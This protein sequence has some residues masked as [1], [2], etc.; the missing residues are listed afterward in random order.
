MALTGRSEAYYTD[1]GGTPQELI[2]A[3]KHGY[4]F[5]G[6]WYAWQK[7]RRGTPAL[8]LPPWAFVSFL[9]NH[10]QV[11]NSAPG[12]RVHQLTGPAAGGR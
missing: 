1:Y 8:G 5:Q 11:A 6:Q 10:D 2:S 3:M 9:E 7:Q 4:L 12:A